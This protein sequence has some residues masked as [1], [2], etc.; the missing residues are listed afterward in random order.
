[1]KKAGDPE[2]WWAYATQPQRVR[3]EVA[4]KCVPLCT[5]KAEKLLELRL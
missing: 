4:G 5:Q 2:P 3:L 1:M